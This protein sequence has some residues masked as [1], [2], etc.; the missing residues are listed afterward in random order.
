[1]AKHKQNTDA[2]S[3]EYLKG[4]TPP[5][6]APEVGHPVTV[7]VLHYAIHEGG[8]RYVAGDTFEID[9]LRA[10]NYGEMLEVVTKE[11]RSHE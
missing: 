4:Q 5:E 8:V 6:A 10:E 7:R 11:D 9:S 1:M 2:E 3:G